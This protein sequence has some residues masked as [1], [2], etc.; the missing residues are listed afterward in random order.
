MKANIQNWS[1]YLLSVMIFV[2]ITACNNLESLILKQQEIENAKQFKASLI[3]EIAT[4]I[5]PSDT[6]F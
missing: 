6:L 5:K 1:T 2:N 4:Q 3:R